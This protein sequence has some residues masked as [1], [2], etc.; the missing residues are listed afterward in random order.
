MGVEERLSRR[1]VGQGL[2]G[3]LGV[4]VVDVA[5]DDSAGFTD[6]L[7]PMEPGA[8]FLERTDEPFAQAVLLGGIGRDVFLLQAVVLD[9][10]ARGTRTK[11]EAIV[12]AQ[13]E[14]LGCAMGP[15]ETVD[16]GVF[17]GSLNSLGPGGPIQTPTQNLAGVAV[18]DGHG[19]VPPSLALERPPE[20]TQLTVQEILSGT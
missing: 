5:G 8:F 3:P 6:V 1:S 9:Q 7:E 13:G 4:E 2:V 18:E 14:V 15:S 16:Q 11:H 17:E 10:C 19:C 20:Y 12:M